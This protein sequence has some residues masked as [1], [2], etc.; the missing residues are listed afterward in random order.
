VDKVL[1]T[2]KDQLR[3]QEEEKRYSQEKVAEFIE[4]K[5]RAL[6]TEQELTCKRPP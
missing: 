4:T 1:A 3:K 5:V 2:I 6:E